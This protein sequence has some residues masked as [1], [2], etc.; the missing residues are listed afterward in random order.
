M[1]LATSYSFRENSLGKKFKGVLSIVVGR[2]G[3]VLLAATE[4]QS[5][6]GEIKRLEALSDLELAVRGLSRDR[7][8]NYV[9]RDK[10]A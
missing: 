3:D 8:V 4:A 10:I 9:F 5:R 2:M 7:I 1:T 6:A